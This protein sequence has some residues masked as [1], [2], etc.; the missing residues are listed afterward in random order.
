[1]SLFLQQSNKF[2]QQ[3]PYDLLAIGKYVLPLDSATVM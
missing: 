1:M 2:F 3:L